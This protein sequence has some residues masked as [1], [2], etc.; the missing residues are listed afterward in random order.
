MR[1]CD[2][3]WI[4]ATD[5]LPGATAVVACAIDH[6]LRRQPTRCLPNAGLS[7]PAEPLLAVNTA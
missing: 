6:R 2:P 4:A 7:L 5:A 3:E 1:R